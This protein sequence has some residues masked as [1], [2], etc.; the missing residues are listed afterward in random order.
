MP[1][2]S[3]LPG[4]NVFSP[5]F[6]PLTPASIIRTTKLDTTTLIIPLLKRVE[7]LFPRMLIKLGR[8]IE[9][10]TIKVFEILMYCLMK[11]ESPT[12]TVAVLKRPI[13]ITIQIIALANPRTKTCGF[14]R[15][16]SSSGLLK[17]R[18]S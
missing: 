3:P 18:I 7:Y 6:F 2:K 1:L 15:F 12:A 11:L 16:P 5:K 8:A 14:L 9:R 17:F 10:P 4:T 13:I